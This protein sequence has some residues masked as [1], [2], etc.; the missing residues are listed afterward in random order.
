MNIIHIYIIYIIIVN[1]NKKYDFLY[2]S[3]SNLDEVLNLE[4]NWL[5]LYSNSYF[6]L[7]VRS[8]CVCVTSI[9]SRFI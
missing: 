1:V 2:F 4:L 3:C 8:V 9:Y 7:S 6:V 5:S